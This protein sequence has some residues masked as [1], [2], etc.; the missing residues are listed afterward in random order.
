MK[1]IIYYRKSLFDQKELESANQYFDCVSLISNIKENSFVIPRYSLYPFVSDQFAELK[2][3]NCILI[4]SE[5]QHYYIADLKNW[6]Y[7][8]SGLTPCTWADLHSL[9][10]D[11][12]QFVL[13]GQTNSKKQNWKECMFAKNK[14]EAI[15]VH[16]RLCDDG[17]I[18]TQSIYIREY[19]PLVKYFDGIGGVPITKEFRFFIAYGQILC[20][21]YYWQNYIDEFDFPP[22]VNEVPEEFLQNVINLIG[23]KSNFYVIDVAQTLAGRWIVI[24]L[25]DGYQ[26]GLSYNDPKL[27]YKNLSEKINTNAFNWK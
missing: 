17:L 23:N 24:E 2:E 16:S 9:P 22:N 14:A 4:N 8:L 7:D 26:S 15:Q 11:G 19:I 20:G 6:V 1:P 18:G 13:K 10:N 3:K 12:T 27:L 21:A 5:N 25:N